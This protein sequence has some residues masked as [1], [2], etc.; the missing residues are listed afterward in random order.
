MDFNGDYLEISENGIGYDFVDCVSKKCG[1]PSGGGIEGGAVRVTPIVYDD[2]ILEDGTI[3]TFNWETN[4]NPEDQ[5]DAEFVTKTLAKNNYASIS[6]RPKLIKVDVDDEHN[7]E[8]TFY[9]VEDSGLVYYGKERHG[10]LYYYNVDSGTI[11]YFE[12]DSDYEI[13]DGIDKLTFLWKHYPTEDY[14]IDPCSSNIIDMYVLTNTYYNEVQTWIGN[15]KTGTFPKAPSAYELKSL[16]QELENNKM[17]SDSIVWHPVNYK[18]I[19]GQNADTDTHCIFKVIKTDDLLSDNEVKKA[20][21]QLIDNYFTTMEAGETFYFTKLSTYIELNLQDMIK[22]CVIV[23]T[24]TSSK[25]GTLFQIKCDDN[26][27]LL[28]SATLDD[29]QIIQTITKENIRAAS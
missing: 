13:V 29:V 3:L 5:V 7:G 8:T 25:F 14:I 24:D 15:G 11:T 2:I 21:V 19:F 23:P 12:K 22:T 28:S 6:P 9:K 10:Y 1:T 27:I 18:L 26:E 16:F 20:V 4:V 17:I